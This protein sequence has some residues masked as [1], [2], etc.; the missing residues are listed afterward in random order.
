ML[1]TAFSMAKHRGLPPDI[2]LVCTGSPGSRMVELADAADALSMGGS[3]I[4]PGFVGEVEFAALIKS[5]LG[6]VFPSLYEGFGMPVL[7][8]M[9]AGRPVACSNCTSLPEI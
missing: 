7:E 2:K 1:L 6:V 5:C 8:A 4:F 3:V 9:A